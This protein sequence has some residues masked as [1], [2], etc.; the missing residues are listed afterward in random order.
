MEGDVAGVSR[1][2]QLQFYLVSKVW[3]ATF[4]LGL[5]AAAVVVVVVV[6]RGRGRGAG[7]VSM[8]QNSKVRLNPS[9]QRQTSLECLR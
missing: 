7:S 9:V 5:V 8:S 1:V 2:L 3:R 6:M 4:S